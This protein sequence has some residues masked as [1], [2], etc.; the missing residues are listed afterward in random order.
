VDHADCISVRVAI[1]DA[2]DLPLVDWGAVVEVDR[3]VKTQRFEL[4][5]Q[6]FDRLT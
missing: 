1:V 5:L 3:R 6:E 4:L 2:E